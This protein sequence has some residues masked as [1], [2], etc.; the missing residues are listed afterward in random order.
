MKK[1][2]RTSV[3]ATCLGMLFIGVSAP[4]SNAQVLREILNRMDTY[5]KSLQSL[6]AEVTMVKYD[7]TLK[8]S[9]TYNGSV[10]YLAK[11][12]GHDR[13]AR[14]D[15]TKPAQESLAVIGDKYELYRP[16]LNQVVYGRTTGGQGKAGNLLSFLTMS[17]DELKSNFD[18]SYIGQEAISGGTQ[19]WHLD[20][21][22]LRTTDYQKAEIW[23]DADGAPRQARI[24]EKNNDTTTLMIS[25]MKKNPTL[26][27]EVFALKYPGSVKKIPG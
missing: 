3:I 21:K 9:E 19:T 1:V 27:G 12:K 6:Q 10:S 14:I 5:N 17:R 15:W 24:L 4:R 23:V 8:I 13:Y 26:K 20:L 18:V 16:R 2:I 22:P 25:G 7:S 11:A